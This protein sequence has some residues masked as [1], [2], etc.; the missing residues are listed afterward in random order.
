MNCLCGCRRQGT[1]R[2]KETNVVTFSKGR[3]M[4]S[5]QM[6]GASNAEV[7]YPICWPES[8]ALR[9]WRKGHMIC[10]LPP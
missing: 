7:D 10:R 2:D 6:D 1:G 4:I 3:E 5:G 8:S 9:T